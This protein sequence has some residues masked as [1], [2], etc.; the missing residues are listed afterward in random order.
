MSWAAC[1]IVSKNYVAYARTVAQSYRRQHPGGRFFVLLV[2]RC[3]GYFDPGSEPFELVEVGELRLPSAERMCFQYTVL[4]LNTAVK[5]Y[6]MA[7]LL[8][9]YG[10]GK[11]IYLDPDILVTG[12][13][14]AVGRLLDE[15]SIVLTPHLTAPI[16]D[17]AKPTELDILR[18]GAYNLGFLAVAATST[19]HRFLEWWQRRLMRGGRM[20]PDLGMHVDQRWVD[21]VPGMFEGV[22]VLRDEGYNVAYWNL[23]SR[24]VTMAADGQVRVNGRLCY[25]FHFSGIDPEDLEPVSRHQTRFRLAELGEGTGRLFRDYRE[26]VLANGYRE[27]RRWPYAFG[28]FSNGI[29]IPDFA[30]RLYWELG[31]EAW[32]FGNP[33][34]A[35]GPDSFFGWLRRREAERPL[36]VRLYMHMVAPWEPT[37][38]PVLRKVFGQQ[39][40]LGGKLRRL[41][42]RLRNHDTLARSSRSQLLPVARQRDPADR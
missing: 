18:A 30:R 9:K 29:Q 7:H 42:R 21:L 15:Y 25:F 40:W 38:T 4:E 20:D 2:D 41:R 24:D 1:T 19:T 3:D 22:C 13:L 16:E 17:E 33:F 37:L 12:G 35:E 26:L 6:F 31:D 28:M 10:I 11:L 39:T 5:P 34:Q 27:T 14:A 8:E 23:H 36:T 32:R